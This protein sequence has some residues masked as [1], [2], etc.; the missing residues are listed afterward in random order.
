M[1]AND[2]IDN[3]KITKRKRTRI[4][5]ENIIRPRLQQEIGSRCPFCISVEVSHFEIHHIDE[6]TT[7]H[8]FKNLLLLCKQCHSK[9]TKGEWPLRK[10][11]DKKDEILKLADFR[12]LESSPTGNFDYKCYGMR[13]DNGRLAMELDN[14]SIATIKVIDKY[15]IQIELQQCDGRRWKGELLLKTGNYG[16]LSFIY[17]SITEI[18]VGR[19]ECFIR[20]IVSGGVRKDQFFFKPLTNHNDY[21]NELMVRETLIND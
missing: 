10:G 11:R 2:G 9:F 12:L 18:E 16:E 13:P 7:N 14:G 15:N 4:P 5:Q 3:F 1:V 21:S 20:Q 8:D 6:D 17:D 19:K